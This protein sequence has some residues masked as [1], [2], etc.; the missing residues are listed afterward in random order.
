MMRAVILTHPR[1]LD[2][3]TTTLIH[4]GRSS[5]VRPQSDDWPQM[6]CGLT[7][8]ACQIM[9]QAYIHS[10]VIRHLKANRSCSQKNESIIFVGT[11]FT[12]RM[13]ITL[14]RLL[15]WWSGCVVRF[16]SLCRLFVVLCVCVRVR[17]VFGRL[18]KFH[19]AKA[20]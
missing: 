9:A 10:R 19:F 1:R 4:S 8:A 6:Q 13:A 11:A 20:L 18:E 7:I 16:S 17:S 2:I 15:R 5:S 12:L 3:I 14:C